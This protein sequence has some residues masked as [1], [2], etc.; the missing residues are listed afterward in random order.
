MSN[1]NVGFNRK[2]ISIIF[3]IA[4]LEAMALSII[5]PTTT[6]TGET[7]TICPTPSNL[8]VKC[9]NYTH[10]ASFGPPLS[11]TENVVEA[12]CPIGTGTGCSN[13]YCTGVTSQPFFPRNSTATNVIITMHYT[14]ANLNVTPSQLIEIKMDI[15][16]TPPST[17]F[18]LGACATSVRQVSGYQFFNFSTRGVSQPAFTSFSAALPIL[19]PT[20]SGPFYAFIDLVPFYTS[21]QLRLPSGNQNNFSIG[22]LELV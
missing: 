6:S 7:P 18:G 4:F 17:A 13:V 14:A 1:T 22:I 19:M 5:L 10:V 15:S 21:C 8:I 11:T 16:T 9:I 20:G 2:Q 3:K 12:G